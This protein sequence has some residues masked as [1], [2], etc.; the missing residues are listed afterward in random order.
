[1]ERP[2]RC[3]RRDDQKAAKPHKTALF[4]FLFTL[5]RSVGVA[6]GAAEQLTTKRLRLDAELAER[7]AQARVTV[8]EKGER[9]V[10]RVDVV[11]LGRH[12]LTECSL[13]N[14]PSV[15]R[16]ASSSHQ[17]PFR[18]PDLLRRRSAL[19]K[20]SGEQV[21]DGGANVDGMRPQVDQYLSG[22]PFTLADEPEQDVLGPDVVVA[23]L[24]RLPQRQLEDLLGSG[25]ER[26]LTGR[27]GLTSSHRLLDLLPDRLERDRQRLERFDRHALPLVDE[28]EQDVLGPD[29]VVIQKPRLLL[30]QKDDP[31]SPIGEALEHPS[32]LVTR[33]VLVAS[34][35]DPSAAAVARY[36]VGVDG[37]PLSSLPTASDDSARIEGC[38][39]DT[40]RIDD[41]PYLTEIASHLIKAGGKRQRPLF[42]INSA[43]TRM[44]DGVSVPDD[45]VRGGVAVELVQVGSLYHDDVIDEAQI[46]RQV[47]S[48]NA[49]W[50]NLRAVLAGDYLLAKAS[51]I[52]ADLGTDVAGLLATTIGELCKGQVAELQTLYNPDRTPDQ[53][54]TSIAGKTASLFAAATRIGGLVAELDPA[55]TDQ[56][57]E[58]GRHYGMA[59][60]V[61]DD[62]LDVIATD[63]QLGKP[64]GK[65][66]IEGVYSLPVI[67][68]LE[69][70][71]GPLRDLLEARVTT[72][73]R[74]DAIDGVRRSPGIDRA[75]ETASGFVD[76][77]R[78][79]ILAV[80]DNK[81]ANALADTASH[82]LTTVDRIRNA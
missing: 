49:R 5:H 9:Q 57:T 39:L 34:E 8:A 37:S 26:N 53:Y 67:Y 72:E 12:R 42:T 21:D 68:A 60:Q 38:L 40:V 16:Q 73:T 2:G 33:G 61:V 32:S 11:G 17:P 46:R 23:E 79:T 59:F 52:A 58:F 6:I 27:R 19:R 71:Q 54:H 36:R 13:E 35:T 65:D 62:I 31:P 10:V 7:P 15:G 78:A 41:D 25:R 55:V 64:A 3:W 43:A 22:H 82:L 29:V 18:R 14:P 44:D 81:A 56:L 1:M 24:Q 66:M 70:D 75:Y 48:V 45:V 50:G 51:E 4:R 30:G 77:A 28:A 20:T 74:F 47:D 80:S 76:Q 69:S 63:E